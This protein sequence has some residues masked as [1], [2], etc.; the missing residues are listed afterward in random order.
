[1]SA[2]HPRQISIADYTYDLPEERIAQ[3]PLEVRD[4]SRLLVYQQGRMADAHFTDLANALPPHSLLVF[5]NTKVVQARLRFQKVTGGIIELFCLEPLE[6]IREVQQAMQQTQ[7]VVW[8]CLVG[9]NKR[10]REGR[11]EM[12]LGPNPEDGILFAERLAPAEEGYAIRFSWTPAE[13][14]FAEV[15]EIAGLLP[16]PPYMNRDAAPEDQNRYQ[17][18]YADAAGAVAAP[19]AGLHFTPRVLEQLNQKKHQAAFVTLHVGAGTFKPVKSE[20]MEH[21]YMHPEQLSVSRETVE[22]L[23]RHLGQPIIPVGTTSMRTLE[24]LYWL[25]VGLSM[26][27]LP[28]EDDQLLVPQWLPYDQRTSLSVQEALESILTYLNQQGLSHLQATTRIL[29][30]PGYQFK[31]CNGIIT[32]FHQPNSTLLL[33]VAAMIGPSWQKVYRHA[34]ANNYRFLSYGDSSLLLP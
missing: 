27:S 24:S 15:L 11:L 26:G 9:N 1:M 16:L 6:P 17:T 10:W 22:Q 33:L 7:S 19:T 8:K 21:H 28:T 31:L 18:I 13:R 3:F 14:T 34:L 30:A 23:L 4:Q 5:N 20:V 25:G 29:I 2:S 32:N 12:P